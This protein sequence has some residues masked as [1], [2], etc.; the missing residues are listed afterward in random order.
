MSPSRKAR[1]CPRTPKQKALIERRYRGLAGSSFG[2]VRFS[3]EN[4]SDPELGGVVATRQLIPYLQQSEAYKGCTKF[5]HGCSALRVTDEGHIGRS[6]MATNSLSHPNSHAK[7]QK[8]GRGGAA[9]TLK[10]L[11][12]FCRC[13]SWNRW[14]GRIF[15]LSHQV[16]GAHAFDFHNYPLFER[17]EG[18]RFG[19]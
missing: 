5:R 7:A 9:T 2:M 15:A 3:G 12:L 6:W 8:K 18:R 4:C 11:S 19:Y 16:S 13:H 1:T 14:K 10:R 17:R